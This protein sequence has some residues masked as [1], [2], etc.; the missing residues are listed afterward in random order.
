[1]ANGNWPILPVATL[2]HRAVD[3]GIPRD[4]FS[5]DNNLVAPTDLVRSLVSTCPQA[6]AAGRPPHLT[7]SDAAPTLVPV[8]LLPAFIPPRTAL[9]GVEATMLPAGLVGCRLAPCTMAFTKGRPE[10]P[11][12]AT[13]FTAA[14]GSLVPSLSPIAFVTVSVGKGKTAVGA[15]H[16]RI[17]G[18][19]CRKENAARQ[20]G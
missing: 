2:N 9:I 5:S 14:A 15:R 8:T 12:T 16:G 1:M 3:L 13:L 20:Q 6:L 18:S 17:G 4:P 11:V 19:R 10:D 7:T